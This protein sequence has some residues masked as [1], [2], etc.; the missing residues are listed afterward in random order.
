MI[1]RYKGACLLRLKQ[2]QTAQNILHDQLTLVEQQGQ[3]HQQSIALVDLAAS[4]VQ[5]AAIRQACD[6]ATMALLCLEQTRS[7]RVFQR[8]L[9]FRHGLKPWENT[10]L[11]KN[12]DEHLQV[13]AQDLLKGT[14]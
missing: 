8:L 2:A 6:F 4:C 12:L 10:I 5:Q 3:V 7:I 14:L 1:T 13:F 9:T 11:V